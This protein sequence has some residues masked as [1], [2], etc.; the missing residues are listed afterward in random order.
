MQPSQ[1][2][3]YIENLG[4]VPFEFNINLGTLSRPGIVTCGMPN[5]K[6]L[7]AEK[8]K[9]PITLCPG[10][11]D[12]ISEMILV[13]CGHFPAVR[14]SV[15]AVGIYPGCLLSFPRLEE[16]DYQ[17]KLAKTKAKYEEVGISYSAPCNGLEA[18]KNL[19]P[20]PQKMVDR[21][22]LGIK[23][24]VAME[25]EAEADREMLCD[26]II[27]LM[28]PQA[29]SSGAGNVQLAPLQTKNVKKGKGMKATDPKETTSTQGFA[30]SDLN[31]EGIP[32][33]TYV[34]DFGNVVIGTPHKKSFRLTNCGRI[35]VQFAFKKEALTKANI[36]IEAIDKNVKKIL[37]NNSMLFHVTF[38]SQARRSKFGRMQERVPIEIVGG[39]QYEIEFRANLTQPELSMSEEELDF[40][41]VCV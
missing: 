14:F 21:N 27:Q 10:V 20:P 7:A 13:E 38:S 41:K 33:A 34:C 26:R 28:K 36:S 2:Y 29:I 1:E 12:N 16:L 35:P 9:V 24:P 40:G 25:I 31:I 18:I 39:P 6:V 19:P 4:K 30:G 11:P 22:R 37:P 23:D 8:V 5:G 32:I 17:D 3:F 15:K